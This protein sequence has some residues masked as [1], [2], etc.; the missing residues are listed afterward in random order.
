M[1]P[2]YYRRFWHAVSGPFL[3]GYCQSRLVGTSSPTTAVYT[4][5]GF[6]PHAASRGQ[7]FA[8]CRLFL[9][10]ASRRSEGRVSVPLWLTTLS[11]QL[12]VIGLVGRYP[13]NYL[14]GRRPLP[15]QAV[16]P[17]T[18]RIG[19][20]I[21]YYPRFLKAI[22]KIGAG[23][24]VL[25]SRPPLPS[26]SEGSLDLH[27]S[28]TPPTFILSQDQTLKKGILKSILTRLLNLKQS[29]C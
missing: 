27:I 25:L 12:P 6:F 14:I 15:I 2:T 4:L 24:Y 29:N 11:G 22:L 26:E 9:I 17:F 18:L 8:H 16:T 28:G 20:T 10:A 7:A 1:G 19:G 13:T 5:A 23:T 3:A 21:E